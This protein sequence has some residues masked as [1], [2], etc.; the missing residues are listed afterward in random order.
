[1]KWNIFVYLLVIRYPSPLLQLFIYLSL[2]LYSETDITNP[3][4]ILLSIYLSSLMHLSIS[5]N[6]IWVRDNKEPHSSQKSRVQ[7][8]IKTRTMPSESARGS[9]KST[10][11][12]AKMS[13]NY[14]LRAV[15]GCIQK[16]L[17]Y[18]YEQTYVSM[19]LQ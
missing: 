13:R 17:L 9:F 6:P 12:F 16:W 18:I 4:S 11:K 19:L 14:D 8:D 2:Y 10:K 7:V 5:F 1:M 3:L 15:E